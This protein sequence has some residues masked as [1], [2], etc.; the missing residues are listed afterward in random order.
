M[1]Y[2]CLLL[3]VCIV[4]GSFDMGGITSTLNAIPENQR[5][6]CFLAWNTTKQE[7]EK[8]KQALASTGF[9]R[10][11]VVCSFLVGNPRYPLYSGGHENPWSG[12][13]P[14]E[15]GSTASKKSI[16]KRQQNFFKAQ[17]TKSFGS[18]KCQITDL[19]PKVS[20]RYPTDDPNVKAAHFYPKNNPPPRIYPDL[21]VWSAK[22]GAW[23]AKE[24]E[25]GFDLQR[26][27]I[28][29]DPF[30]RK[31]FFHIVDPSFASEKISDGRTV[32]QFDGHELKWGTVRPSVRV[33]S[34]HAKFA[35]SQAHSAWNPPLRQE[36]IDQLQTFV[37][38]SSPPASQGDEGGGDSDDGGGG[39]S[40]D[41]GGDSNSDDGGG[42]GL[43]S[44]TPSPSTAPPRV[45]SVNDVRYRAPISPP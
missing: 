19:E 40:D 7:E 8:T 12:M 42:G 45:Y 23:L 25:N 43:G 11:Y 24:L 36:K 27:C 22:N 10:D 33:L 41:D 30:R 28:V 39:R 16:K 4:G 44:V 32:G 5:A 15:R 1:R 20:K 14:S 17:L 21:D 18:K 31:L 37:T 6:E 34:L 35:L 29:Y 13:T 9:L 26:A 3:T 2:V 38:L